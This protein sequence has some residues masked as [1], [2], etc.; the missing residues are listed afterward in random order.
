MFFERPYEGMKNHLKPLF[1]RSKVDN[2][3]VDKILI[4]GGV[5]VNLMPQFL[6][7]KIGKYDTDLRPHDMVLS[8]YEGKIGHTLGVIHVDVTIR[9]ITMP[10]IF[11]APGTYQ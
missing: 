10:I 8:N 7:R 6:L 1:I 3:T 2:T 11:M 9:S 4:D 5:V